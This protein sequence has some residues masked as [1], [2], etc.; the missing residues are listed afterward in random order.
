MS[1][2][3]EIEVVTGT[4]R[5]A[6]KLGR[7][8]RRKVAVPV[9]DARTELREVVSQHRALTRA[10]VAISHMASDR[11]NRETGEKMRCRLPI[12]AQEECK[13][14]AKAMSK[15]ASSLASEMAS[16]LK[17][18]PIYDL[19]LSRVYGLGPV[20]AAY[21]VAFVDIRRCEKPSQL[22]RY[23][24]VAPCGPGGRLER[25]TRGQPIGFNRDLR[26]IL[27]QAAG[28]MLRNAARAT[29]G[30]SSTIKGEKR[31]FAPAPCSS[32]Y[33]DAWA[34]HRTRLMHSER[35]KDGKIVV[36]PQAALAAGKDPQVVSALRATNCAGR[37]RAMQILAEDL[38]TVWRA[39]EGLPIWPSYYAAKLGYAHGG[40][41]IDVAA[42]GPRLLTVEEALELVGDVGRIAGGDISALRAGAFDEDDDAEDG[43]P[44]SMD[45]A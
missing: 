30:W 6:T 34:A 18:Q 16:K 24:G 17:G 12:D 14:V 38:Y 1:A 7:M 27:W 20:V 44:E 33:L 35:V 21:L 25:P 8:G 43:E 45:V 5:K 23:L 26:S 29:D 10:S 36:A 42:Q 32:K 39:I 15:R 2:A 4:N 19:Y 22:A 41:K 40:Q 9:V 37:W 28:A 3:H 11:T 31:D 13:A